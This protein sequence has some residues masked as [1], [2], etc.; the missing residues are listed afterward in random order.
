M[1]I[2]S[3]YISAFGG[4]KDFSLELSDGMQ[5]I[6]GDNEAG[7]TTVTEF[8]K[9]MFYGTGK[10]AAGQV[11][12]TREKYTPFDGTQ[13]GGRIRFEKGGRDYI[14]ERQFRKSDATDKVTI[15]DVAA[16]KIEPCAP[17]IGRELFGISVGAFERSVFIAN[18]PDITADDA[19]SG[20]I[21]QKLSNAALSGRDD[22]SCAKVLKR[23]DD[24]RLKLI[25]K[26]GRTGSQIADINECNT[27]IEALEETDRLARKKQEMLVSLAG[28]KEE[29]K[30]IT[31]EY[32]AAQKVLDKAKDIENAQKLK[33]YLELKTQLDEVTAKLT[34]PDGTVADE[35]FLKKFEFGFSK[36]DGVKAKIEAANNELKALREAAALSDSSP[37]QIRAKIEAAKAQA[38][39]CDIKIEESNEKTQAAKARSDELKGMLDA[40]KKAKKPVNIPLVIIAAIL[41][42]AGAV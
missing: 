31:A 36:L 35:M 39:E 23:I 32:E 2:K 4:L 14:I 13:A 29:L 11:M 20:E 19:A 38:E 24:A 3:I 10:R 6:Y 30:Q 40:A 1:R 42:A 5:V 21:N 12:S 18:T 27:L 25:S 37:E 34:L 22:V 41:L 7:K 17:D 16:G 33:E 15:T 28:A 9:A 26:S 8:I